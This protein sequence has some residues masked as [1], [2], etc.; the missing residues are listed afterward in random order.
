MRWRRPW[1]RT[2]SIPAVRDLALDYQDLGRVEDEIPLLKRW[3]E[4]RPR[5][6]FLYSQLA[7]TYVHLGRIQEAKEIYARAKRID[8][9][10]AGAYIDEGYFY[11]HS[12]H[13]DHAKADFES[14]IS[15]DTASPYG[16]HHLGSYLVET[17]KYSEGEKYLREALKRWK[18]DPATSDDDLLHTV[19]WLGRA[20][21]PREPYTQ[22]NDMR[23]FAW[24]SV[25][26][27]ESRN[28]FW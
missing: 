21:L 7:G 8:G 18:Q 13:P 26:E 19:Q 10:E 14:A 9:S 1:R 23:N 4:K 16:Y 22:P 27:R 15:V 17:H 5:D 2:P 11:L 25:Y 6:Y 12:G 28:P 24:W 20:I 3:I